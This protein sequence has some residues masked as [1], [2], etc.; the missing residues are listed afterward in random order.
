MYPKLVNVE[1]GGKKIT[2]LR[3]IEKYTEN[4]RQRE[5]VIA[6]LGRQDIVGREALGRLLKSLR[7]YTDEVLVTPDEINAKKVFEYGPVV[8]M[9]ALWDEIGLRKWIEEGC[10]IDKGG[11]LGEP[12]VFAMVLN[13]LLT[14]RSELALVEWLEGV[15]IEELEEK[16]IHESDIKARAERFYRTLDWLIKGKEKI[17]HQIY[18]WARTLLPV[19]VVFYDITNLQF[20]GEGSKVARRGYYRLGKRNH[21]QLLLGL[22]MID[23]I[24]VGHYLF[25]GNRAEKTTL[26]WISEKVKKQ[27]KVDRIIFV[28]DRGIVSVSNLECIQGE[29]NGYIVGI[30]RRRNEEVAEILESDDNGYIEIRENLLAKECS[31]GEGGIRRI[32]CVNKDRAKEDREKRESIIKELQE[33]L[34][35]LRERVKGGKLKDVKSIIAKAEHI[36]TEKHGKRYFDYDVKDG[37]FRFWLKEE[38]TAYEEKLDG[39]FILKTIEKDMPLERVVLRYKDLMEVERAFRELKDFIEVTP[40]Y[41]YKYRRIKAHIFICVLALLLKRFLDRKLALAKIKISSEKAIEELKS[42]KVVVNKVGRLCL[43]Y[44]VV[45]TEELSKIL[46]AIGIWRLPNILGNTSPVYRKNEEIQLEMPLEG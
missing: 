19:D 3:L 1:S 35:N 4:G 6:N 38:S 43:K 34:E 37:G 21:K 28:F 16:R 18:E 7:R 22:I 31:M 13:H 41:H 29:G 20:E 8:G 15:Y 9:R 33:E 42:I 40:I 23:N 2:Y 27:Y 44:V 46:R 12:G 30:K 17:E 10:G 32:I 25:R 11:G 5:R 45:P 24:P 26:K 36:V 39:K 14:P